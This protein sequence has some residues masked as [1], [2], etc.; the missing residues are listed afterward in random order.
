MT[1]DIHLCRW[2][3]SVHH[4]QNHRHTCMC[5]GSRCNCLVTEDDSHINWSLMYSFG[6]V[7]SLCPIQKLDY[8]CYDRLSM[9]VTLALRF[10]SLI[11]CYVFESVVRLF[12]LCSTCKIF[13]H[14]LS[15]ALHSQLCTPKKTGP[16]RRFS[17]RGVLR[18]FFSVNKVNIQVPVNWEAHV[19]DIISGLRSVHSLHL[20]LR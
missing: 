4:S 6:Y 7:R 12:R 14:F 15:P 20:A 8:L 17:S 13:R 11:C 10:L 9:Q 19:I 18:P 5:L 1:T 2:S 16:P 3:N